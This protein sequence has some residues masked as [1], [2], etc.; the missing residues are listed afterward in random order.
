MT[1]DRTKLAEL[2]KIAR[3]L[4][5][6]VIELSYSSKS[7]HIGSSLSC[8]DLLA[9]L[10]FRFLRVTPGQPLAKDRDRFLMS[11]GHAC[12]PFY[13]CLERL[14]FLPSDVL[15]RYGEEGGTLGHHPLKCGEYGIEISTGSL[16]HGLSVGCGLAFAAKLAQHQWRTVVLMSD[17]EQNEGTVWEAAMF[18]AQH[19]LD[20]V[21]AIVDF[22]K[23]QALG[24]NSEIIGIEKL[25]ERYRSFGW[26]VRRIDGH[27]LSQIVDALDAFPFEVGKPSAIVADTIK[28]KG[29]SFMENSLLWHYRC[30][31]PTEYQA[32]LAELDRA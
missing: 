15:R 4:R 1:T 21:L 27:D 22:N 23:M 28:G 3:D 30:P 29:I 7:G 20:N 12:V 5:R 11:K 2:R 6:Q 16:G 32:A 26:A 10:Y 17:G 25:D 24:N 9:A 14:G 13:G 31:D 18:A 8:V 19:R